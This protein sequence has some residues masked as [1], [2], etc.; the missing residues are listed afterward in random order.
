MQATIDGPRSHPLTAADHVTGIESAPATWIYD[1]SDGRG[2]DHCGDH[3]ALAE[4][5]Y[6]V[7]TL[8]TDRAEYKEKTLVRICSAACYS[9][10]AGEAREDGWE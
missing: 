5:D 8:V 7:V 2:C 4:G 9:D 1:A 6:I 3:I 10:W